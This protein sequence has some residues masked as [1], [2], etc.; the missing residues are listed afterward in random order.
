MS[1]RREEGLIFLV[2][3]TV[4]VLLLHGIG[5]VFRDSWD[6][7]NILLGLVAVGGYIGMLIGFALLVASIRRP[8]G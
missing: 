3:S 6:G 7:A 4:V 8:N 1:R 2:G 5:Y